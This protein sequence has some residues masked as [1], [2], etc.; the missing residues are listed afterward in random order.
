MPWP[1]PQ[2]MF[3]TSTFLDPFTMEIQSSPN[4]N[5][6]KERTLIVTTLTYYFLR[7]ISNHNLTELARSFFLVCLSTCSDLRFKNVNVRSS[8]NMNSI[9]VGALFWC[10]N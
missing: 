4:P 1:G 2:T 9:C 5:Q 7:K 3:L 6:K 10:Y 8:C